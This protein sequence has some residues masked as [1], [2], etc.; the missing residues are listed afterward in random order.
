MKDELLTISILEKQILKCWIDNPNLILED[1]IFI[2]E[3]TK[4]FQFILLNLID[5]HKELNEEHI[6][7]SAIEYVSKESVIAIQETKYQVEKLND[8]IQKLRA[9]NILHSFRNE[10]LSEINSEDTDFDKVVSIQSSLDEAI[11]KI[12]NPKENEGLSFKDLIDNH[13]DILKDR[14]NGVHTTTGDYL[15]DKIERP[16]SGI[17]TIV[18]YSGSCK[19]TFVATQLKTRIAK[20][21][22]T[23]YFNTE[24][25]VEG[26]MDGIL[27]SLIKETYNDMRGKMNDDEHIDFDNIIDKCNYLAEH[28]DKSK[29]AY[30][31]NSSVCINDIKKFCLLQRKKMNLKK[32]DLLFAYIDLM[33]MV[34]EFQ[35][36][37]HGS[38]RSDV[39]LQALN[40]LNT[41]A[42]TNN[43]LFI[44]TVQAKRMPTGIKI[45]KE[46]DLMK[47]QLDASAIRDSSGYEERS[48]LVLSIFNPYNIVHKNPCSEIIRQITE[49]IIYVKS[50]KNTYGEVGTEVYYYFDVEY[51]NLYPYEG[52]LP[53]YGT[54]SVEEENNDEDKNI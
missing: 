39:I 2:S 34:K 46:E 23:V 26:V 18:G 47:F 35:D 11:E 5:E 14:K 8:Y 20:R 37:T 31:P 10:L 49:P 51:K 44:G 28:S 32:N 19:S 22:P 4:E 17:W 53:N 9:K 13:I 50:L 33:S 30:Y 3:T 12:E 21:L 52:E 1:D 48:R 45:N 40:K 43:I 38:N 27:P 6:L 24:L 36:S 25:S 15:L 16:V 54:L 29:F 41:I 7:T 42:L